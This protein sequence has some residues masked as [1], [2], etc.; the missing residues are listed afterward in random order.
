MQE[1]AGGAA[2][3]QAAEQLFEEDKM[4]EEED[5]EREI[6]DQSLNILR[7]PFHVGSRTNTAPTIGKNKRNKRIKAI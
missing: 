5:K 3:E 7:P 1:D 4:F 6:G 2:L